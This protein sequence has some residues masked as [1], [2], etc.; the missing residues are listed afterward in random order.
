MISSEFTGSYRDASYVP[1]PD[2]ELI[3]E[4]RGFNSNQVDRI[5]LRAKTD[6]YFLASGILGY[7][8]V[9]PYTHGP[10][11]R[12][13]EDRTKRRRMG[14]APR[15]HLK[16]TLWTITDS[17]GLSLEDPNET[18][19][20]IINEIEDNAVGFL[21][22]IKA[23]WESN[24]LLR[25]LFPE[26][27][28]ERITGPGSRWS[29][30]KAC[31]HRST[32]YKEWTYNAIG[33]GGAVTSRHFSHI[34]GD[35]LIGLEA[36]ESPATMKYAITYA[37]TLEPLLI[38]M[39]ENFIDFIGT[40]WAI[41]DLYRAMLQ[42]YGDDILYFSREDLERVPRLPL[43]ALRSFGFGNKR[44][45]KPELSDDELES[46]I[47][48]EQPIFPRKFSLERLHRLSTIDPELYYAQFKNNP[49]ADGIKDFV[50]EKLNW[51][52]F[53]EMG[54]VVYRDKHGRLQR[55]LRDQL[56]IVMVADPN[57]GSLTAPD[58]PAI[59]VAAQ[60]PKSQVF[61]FDAWSK[62]V[63]PDA[64]VD[65]IF[66][67]YQTWQPRVV[68]IEKAGMSSTAFYFKKKARELRVYIN[69]QHVTPKNR[70]KSTKIRK[71]LQPIVNTRAMYLRKEQS[72][73]RHHF[74][75]HPDLENDDEIEALAYCTELWRTPVSQ[76]EQDEEDK[77]IQSIMKRRS[78]L[79]GYGA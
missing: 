49:I 6:R 50:A 60:S 39:D 8:D 46:L 13:I 2:P 29:S 15:G 14:L 75:F 54:S 71:A 38:D 64:F 16:S 51:F 28:P 59:V 68:G 24:D 79:T 32:S 34:K 61:V 1:T 66:E 7:R 9:N 63:L 4:V 74:Q 58:L 18:R 41:H 47:G 73:L 56:D 52:D 43:E 44:K 26:L 10:M 65:R 37:K 3:E 17:I 40:R 77:A 35:D 25:E 62:R 27:I 72:T 53:D 57:S 30:A 12:F 78:S 11:C 19:I 5:K 55:W 42:A 48:T 33:L 45:D 67:M 70:D 36:R 20:L 22:E 76:Q 31:L 69:T 21:S 23:H